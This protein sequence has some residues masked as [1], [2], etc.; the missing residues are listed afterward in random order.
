VAAVLCVLA[1]AVGS[2]LSWRAMRSDTWLDSS[3]GRPRLFVGAIGMAAG[4]LFAL[5]LINQSLVSLM[6]DSCLR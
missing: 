6:V 1:A 4:A 2:F 3:G 5:V